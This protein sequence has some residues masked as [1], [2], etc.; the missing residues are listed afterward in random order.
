MAEP[1]K[2]IADDVEDVLRAALGDNW[3]KDVTVTFRADRLYWLVALAEAGIASRRA[4]FRAAPGGMDAA[5]AASLGSWRID[6]ER[7][8]AA[9]K[10]GLAHGEEP[11]RCVLC[12]ET[13]EGMG[14][15]PAPLSTTGLACNVCNDA[16]VLPARLSALPKKD[17]R[18]AK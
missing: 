18:G 6:L 12:G 15:N 16:K 8:V 1:N 10:A 7:F 2:T 9:V 17:Q 4:Q 14:H 13:V 3:R 11:T 5:G